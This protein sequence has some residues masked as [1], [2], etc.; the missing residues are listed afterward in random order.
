[1]AEKKSASTKVVEL[2]RQEVSIEQR[3]PT[4]VAVAEADRPVTAAPGG[5]HTPVANDGVSPGVLG[6]QDPELGNLGEG[7]GESELEVEVGTTLRS[8]EGAEVME[9]DEQLDE[10][11]LLDA[12]YAE[13]GDPSTRAFLRHQP[14]DEGFLEVVIG[15]DDRIQVTDITRSY[16]WRCI[17]SLLITAGDGSRWIGTGW[18]ISPR[19]LITAGH[20]VYIHGH[21]GWARRVQ[22]IPG[23]DASERPFGSCVATEFRSVTGWT[24]D[25]TREYDYAAIILP[26]SCRFGDDL[27][28]FGYANYSDS[29]LQGKVANLSG[30][31]GDKPSGTQWFHSRNVGRVTEATLLYDIDTAG[32]QS[33]AP[34]WFLKDG[35]RYAIGIHTNG[36]MTGN[37]ATRINSQVFSNLSLWKEQGS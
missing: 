25:R 20:C 34:V 11:L 10:S 7:D 31:P 32:G 12:W 6:A 29:R 19:T 22:V 5:P 27:G 13:Y 28:W 8:E 16:P 3:P 37:S 24:E 17:C 18:L 23:R 15:Q 1:M 2:Y 33:G 30:Y 9:A 4:M 36:A 26:E 21:G 14:P 35:R